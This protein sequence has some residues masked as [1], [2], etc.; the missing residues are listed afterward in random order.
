MR[1]Y[2]LGKI[3]RDGLQAAANRYQCSQGT[4]SK[5]Q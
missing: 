5:C 3:N 2:L 4:Q 1:D